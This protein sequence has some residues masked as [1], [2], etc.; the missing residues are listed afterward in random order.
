MQLTY[1]KLLPDLS[2]VEMKL[3]MEPGKKYQDQKEGCM[4]TGRLGR[5]CKNDLNLVAVIYPIIYYQA[6]LLHGACFAG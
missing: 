5:G 4:C 1:W 2:P 3:R 6:N